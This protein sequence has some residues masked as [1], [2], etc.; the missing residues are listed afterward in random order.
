MCP[1]EKRVV[2]YESVLYICLFECIGVSYNE[3][4]LCP[5]AR[6]E[7]N[8][9]TLSTGSTVLLQPRS[10]FVNWDDK[11]YLVDELPKKVLVWLNDG[12]TPINLTPMIFSN[13]QS[14]FVTMNNA[15]FVTNGAG[16]V[17]IQNVAGSQKICFLLSFT[18]SC[19]GLFVDLN[20]KASE[21]ENCCWYGC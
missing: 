3:P 17:R 7:R 2:I 18:S 8:A 12:V 15:A 5:L 19:F 4:K 13:P 14:V 10:I 6:W 16:I 21:R 1:R 9:T 11:I 20:D